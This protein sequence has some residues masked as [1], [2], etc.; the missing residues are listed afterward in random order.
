MDDLDSRMERT[1]D[2]ARKNGFTSADA[3]ENIKKA[4]MNVWE[5]KGFFLGDVDNK[6]YEH[7]ERDVKKEYTLSFSHLDLTPGAKII[8]FDSVKDLLEGDLFSNRKAVETI[9]EILDS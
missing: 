7:Y 6:H 5:M 8:N 3:I 4:V 2:I 1:G 9:L